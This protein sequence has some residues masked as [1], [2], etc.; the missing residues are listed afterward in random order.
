MSYLGQNNWMW[1]EC[2]ISYHLYKIIR[3]NILYIDIQQ[4]SCYIAFVFAVCL[5]IDVCQLVCAQFL[6]NPIVLSSFELNFST[7]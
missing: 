2:H 4:Y 5:K 6:F 1:F 3:N 7:S